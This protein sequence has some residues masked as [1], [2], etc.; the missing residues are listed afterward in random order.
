MIVGTK[1]GRLWLFECDDVNELRAAFPLVDW[2]FNEHGKFEIDL[3]MPPG[4]LFPPL[5]SHSEIVLN[6]ETKDSIVETL[7]AVGKRPL[8]DEEIEIEREK[9]RANPD[10]K[11]IRICAGPG[12]YFTSGG[13]IHGPTCKDAFPPT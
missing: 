7:A 1:I 2:R 6:G 3:Q 4:L 11:A 12:C 9:R 8:T 13:N 10:P 5:L